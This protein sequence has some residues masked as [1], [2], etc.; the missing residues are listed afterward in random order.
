MDAVK[1]IYSFFSGN[2]SNVHKLLEMGLPITKTAENRYVEKDNSGNYLTSPIQRLIDG[3]WNIFDYKVS[4]TDAFNKDLNRSL[5]NFNM[6]VN[7][8]PT[9]PPI[10]YTFP[11][12][13]NV[14]GYVSNRE[15]A[16]GSIYISYVTSIKSRGERHSFPN[17][18]ENPGF[19][20]L[21]FVPKKFTGHDSILASKLTDNDFKQIKKGIHKT[22]SRLSGQEEEDI[23]KIQERVKIFMDETEAGKGLPANIG[24]NLA[25]FFM[26]PN[27]RKNTNLPK[28]TGHLG[29]TKRKGGPGNIREIL[30]E[31]LGNK[32]K[33]AARGGRLSGRTRR[34]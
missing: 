30:N 20:I 23:P 18:E 32:T 7:V 16:I 1:S 34:R 22:L 27:T 11:V 4:S 28:L 2:P 25:S 19:L 3:R 21:R 5:R 33:R 12:A 6:E 31:R 13:S 15:L 29:A 26:G 24:A 9:E 8:G 17:P 10:L 14:T